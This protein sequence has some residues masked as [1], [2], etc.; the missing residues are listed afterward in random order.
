MVATLIVLTACASEARKPSP[1]STSTPSRTGT[2]WLC[3]PG[4]RGNPCNSDLTATAVSANR[5]VTRIASKPAEDP[6]VDCFYVYPTVSQQRG[7]N[8]DLRVEAAERSVAVAQASRFSEMCDVWA[9]M[10]RQRTVNA[11]LGARTDRGPSDVAYRSLRDGWRDYL[12]NHSD[13]R[14]FVLIGHSQGATVLARLLA[15]DIEPDAALRERLVSAILLGGNVE[16]PVGRDVGGS[17]KHVNAC[18]RSGQTGC[19]IA[20]SAFL[21]E[22]PPSAL[23][24]IAG[25]GVSFLAGPVSDQPRRVLCTN[26]A[27]LEGGSGALVPFFPTPSAG[28]GLVSTPWVTQPDLYTA[29]CRSTGNAT[30][31]DVDVTPRAGKRLAVREDQGPAWGLHRVDVNIALGNLVEVVGEQARARR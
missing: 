1:R 14:P 11:L 10:Y 15:S 13:G 20:Y 22:P 4:M 21:E 17:F 12:D 18:R 23:F 2:V 16:V 27:N 5:S 3:R 25:Q 24:G 6:P 7:P 26:P 8:A 29:T 19:V 9:P 28:Q 31:L 30:W